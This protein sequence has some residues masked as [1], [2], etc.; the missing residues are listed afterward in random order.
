MLDCYLF[1]DNIFKLGNDYGDKIIEINNYVN[2]VQMKTNADIIIVH[3][4]GEMMK[5]SDECVDDFGVK[6]FIL[7]QAL[8]VDYF[9]LNVEIGSYTY[10][11][12]NEMST[13]FMYRFGFCI[14]AVFVANKEVDVSNSLEDEK[15]H[16]IRRSWDEVDEYVSYLKNNCSFVYSIY[17]DNSYTNVVEKCIDEL[18]GNIEEF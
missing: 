1:P 9:V 14:D 13:A 8:S 18:S 5:Y 7:A 12:F 2:N 17:D 6:S 11:S 16:F 3:F 15:I 4:P 10:T